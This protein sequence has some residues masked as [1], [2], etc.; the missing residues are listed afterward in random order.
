MIEEYVKDEQLCYIAD[1]SVLR[2]EKPI[3]YTRINLLYLT[4]YSHNDKL[5]KIKREYCD[6]SKSIRNDFIGKQMRILCSTAAVLV[7]CI[8]RCHWETG[9]TEYAL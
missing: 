4:K 8:L 2:Y 1:G 6:Y 9:K 5:V 3:Y 7:E